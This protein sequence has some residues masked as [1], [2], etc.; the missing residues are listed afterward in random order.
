MYFGNKVSF[1]KHIAVGRTIRVL[2][3][4]FSPASSF[5][6]PAPR[7][8][9]NKRL[10][11]LPDSMD[12]CGY[13]IHDA[14][15]DQHHNLNKSFFGTTDSDLCFYLGTFDEIVIIENLQSSD[16]GRPLRLSG[17]LLCFLCQQHRA[18]NLSGQ[19]KQRAWKRM[20]GTQNPMG[21]YP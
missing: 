5:V 7:P 15:A 13:H 12:P 21:L 10:R 17:S 6:L 16:N 8:H 14:Q 4:L 18:N 11:L 19:W 1:P 3:L 9:G 20:T 2:R